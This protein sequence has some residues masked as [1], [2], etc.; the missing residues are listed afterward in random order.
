MILMFPRN[1]CWM[2]VSEVVESKD[3]AWMWLK[4]FRQKFMWIALWLWIFQTA[5][6]NFAFIVKLLSQHQGILLRTR[7][8]FIIII[9]LEFLSYL[10]FLVTLCF[11]E[12][13]WFEKWK[14]NGN[15][16]LKLFSS[17]GK[18][19]FKGELSTEHPDGKYF[20]PRQW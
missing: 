5:L 1:K 8:H 19:A 18:V 16:R 14:R 10:G 3:S 17:R 20:P 11:L 4:T 9:V 2:S 12:K 6:W 15:V 7:L 13:K